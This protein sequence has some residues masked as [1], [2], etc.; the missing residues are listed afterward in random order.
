MTSPLPRQP[1]DD[2]HTVADPGLPGPLLLDRGV[3][4]WAVPGVEGGHLGKE[5][6]EEQG[7]SSR[8]QAA[9]GGS[10]GQYLLQRL[11]QPL[12]RSPV[13]LQVRV[14]TGVP[15]AGGQLG[16]VGPHLGKT[17]RRSLRRGRT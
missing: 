9:G 3:E 11:G 10:R 14:G 1:R 2:D 16:D 13:T 12:Q 6:C 7:A 4:G 8:G 17:S 5:Q 15:R